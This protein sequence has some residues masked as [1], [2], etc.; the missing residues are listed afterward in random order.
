MSSSDTEGR[1][2]DLAAIT[3]ALGRG[4]RPRALELAHAALQRVEH[5]SLL[6]HLIDGLAQESGSTPDVAAAPELW[7]RYGGTLARAG[8][9]VEGRAALEIALVLEPD[10]YRARIDAG[11]VAFMRAELEDALTHFEHAAALMP[12]DP[13]P[14]ASLA[15]IAARQQRHGDAR[16]LAE[17]ALALRPGL[18]TAHMAIARADLLEGLADRTDS[19]M[20]EL[21][22]SA[23]LNDAQQV[24]AL[25]LRADARDALDRTGEAFADYVARNA[26]LERV[27]AP[28]IAS[29]LGERRI[30]QARRLAAWFERT[31]PQ[32]WRTGPG[33]DTVRAV[34][35]HVFLLGFPRS[36]T[37][38]LEKVLAGHPDV[39]TLQ[40]IDHLAA[41]GEHLLADDASLQ[42]LATLTPS[43]ARTLREDYWR[44]VGGSVAAPLAGRILVDKM[45]LHTVAL[46]LIARLFP[47]AKVLFALRDPRDVV[48]SCFRRR[49]QVNAAMFEFLTL[50]GAARYYDAVMGLA[51]R[52]RELLPLRFLEVRHEAMVADFED[53]ARKVL[54][55]IG[56]DWNPAV[57]DFADRALSR[58]S[59]PSDPQLARGLSSEGVGQW[60]RY[61]SCL[62][63][64][65][66]LLAP[67]VTRYGYP[68][69]E[70]T[71]GPR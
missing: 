11:T 13:E 9:L 67:W 1:V 53:E 41:A 6:Q 57:L 56:A 50:E 35:E 64:V 44:S 16:A 68:A 26:I 37:T 24:G 66:G 20:T 21:L 71:A 28:R 30:E 40:E 61:Q 18:V 65:L 32:P 8:R 12:G 33:A 45:P 34:R 48:L 4:D 49:F 70:G 39:S 25:D 5:L 58:L 22:D 59:T 36:G 29:E 62:R 69:A 42:A 51:G 63:P 55:F 46:P 17:R 10:A 7:R 38:L 3:A 27:N 31:P 47:D 43:Q 14:L 19:R 2:S 60:R 54:E 52:Y 15:A 23:S